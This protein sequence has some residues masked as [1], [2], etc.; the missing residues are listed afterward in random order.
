MRPP[1]IA[2][3]RRWQTSARSRPSRI[4]SFR[5]QVF[6]LVAGAATAV[7]RGEL[8]RDHVATVVVPGLVEAVG[9]ADLALRLITA[10]R[11]HEGE[12]SDRQ[13]PLCMVRMRALLIRNG[14]H[15]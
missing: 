10:R 3:R 1:L 14:V 11:Q 12:Q 4:R 9:A 7:S 6:L 2:E 13:P 5:L 8:G 15:E